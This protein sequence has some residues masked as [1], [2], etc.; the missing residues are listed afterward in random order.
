MNSPFEI[1]QHTFGYST[2]R[3]RQLEVV[4]HVMAGGSGLVLMPTGGGKSLCFQIPALAR[5]GLGLVISPLI[6]LMHDQVQALVQAGV[7][8]AVYN[9]SLSPADKQAVRAQALSGALKLLYVAPETLNTDFFQSFVDQLNLSVIAVD[10]AHCVSQWGHDF[11]PDY[12]HVANLRAQHPT[13]PL[14]ALTATA[15]PQTRQEIMTRLGLDDEP[16]FASSF[17]R[18]N[19]RYEIVKKKDSKEKLWDFIRGRHKDEAGIVYCLSRKKTEETAEWLT[20]NGIAAFAY[21]AGM[22]AEMRRCTQDRFIKE[23]GIVICATIAFGMGI[24]KPDVRFVAH[25]DLPKSI[26]GYYQETGR[27][28]RDGNPATAWLTY[29]SG[30][31]MQLRRF[32]DQGDGA[33]A[34]KDLSHQKL[35]QMQNYCEVARCRRHML[36]S[37]FGETPDAQ[38][39]ACD[40]CVP[41]IAAPC[42]TQHPVP[43]IAVSG[44]YQKVFEALRKWRHKTATKL[45]LP[46][47]VVCHDSTL[48]ALITQ[49]PSDL[50]ELRQVPGFGDVKV[51]R[52]GN[53]ILK[54]LAE[55]LGE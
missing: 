33:R 8:A 17:D 31:A 15:D 52:F 30:D 10:E 38:C 16:I 19:I 34:F 11:R 28:G 43:Q 5:P 3:G 22:D 14:L 24:D 35:R 27:A 12:L 6:A 50:Y 2:F 51:E 26:E 45:N 7:P 53:A 42:T 29:S 48:K 13:V 44:A 39:R 41:T 36:L 47:Y 49:R 54:V 32:I 23:D 21:H 55:A 20:H 18:P 4:T 37:Y 1:L 25:L 40:V 46:A 9:S